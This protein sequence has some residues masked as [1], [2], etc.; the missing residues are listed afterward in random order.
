MRAHTGTLDYSIWDRWAANPD[1]PV[2][3][4]EMAA[5]EAEK[6]RINDAEFEKNNPDFC[7]QAS[8]ACH[9]QHHQPLASLLTPTHLSPY[10]SSRRTLRNARLLLGDVRQR[11]KVSGV[12]E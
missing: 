3:K 11:L 7:N 8:A 12:D 9:Q 6:E 5:L 4:A 1:D 10:L 2:T